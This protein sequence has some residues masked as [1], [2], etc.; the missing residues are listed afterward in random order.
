MDYDIRDRIRWAVVNDNLP[1]LERLVRR[2]P[3]YLE[4]FDPSNGWSSLH[5]ASDKGYYHICVF[6]ISQGHDQ[7]EISLSHDRS[8]ALHLAAQKNHEQTVHFLA[9][10]IPRCLDWLNSQHESALM[11]AARNGHDP[12]VT[13]LLDFGADIDLP[14]GER[15]RPLHIAAAYGH[16]KTLRTLVDRNADVQ[17]PN[18]EGWRPVQYCSTYQVQDYL[19]SLIH[20]RTQRRMKREAAS[21]NVDA[22]AT[23]SSSAPATNNNITN[24]NNA[25]S[26]GIPNL[27]TQQFTGSFSSLRVPPS[28]LQLQKVQQRPIQRS[29]TSTKLQSPI[30]TKA[31]PL[32]PISTAPP[33]IVAQSSNSSLSSASSLSTITPTTRQ[34]THNAAASPPRLANMTP[35]T[36][37]QPPGISTVQRPSPLFRSTSH[38]KDTQSASSP[39]AS[40]SSTSNLN[41][42]RT[43]LRGLGKRRSSHNRTRLMDIAV[44]TV[45]KKD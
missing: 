41:T 8:T 36:P 21:A 15:N 5:Y 32:T 42:G 33:S 30:E 2:Y 24:N 45:H 18:A 19:Q 29:S 44:S 20:E 39:P 11:V 9:Q 7:T 26:N 10:H 34:Q 38:T 4:N 12:C 35:Q 16:L 40:S 37:S 3:E 14:N 28:A 43:G 13:L 22:E 25:I 17:T 6:L 27:G 31:P 1:V 23:S